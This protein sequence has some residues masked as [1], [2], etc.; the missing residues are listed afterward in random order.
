MF[1]DMLEIP[2]S[3]AKC[4]ETGALGAAIAAG[5]GVGIFA[6]FGD[7]VHAT[8]REGAVHKPAPSMTAHFAERYAIYLQLIDAMKP[9]W[10]QMARRGD[11]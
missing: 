11:P 3:V 5:V 9:V 2:I 4:D 10:Q 7:G 6:N 8:V 1:A